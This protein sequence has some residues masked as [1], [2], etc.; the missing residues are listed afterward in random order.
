MNEAVSPPVHRFRAQVRE[1]SYLSWAIAASVGVH[2]LVYF[3]RYAPPLT[4]PAVEIDLTMSGHIGVA[5]PRHPA[6]KSATPPAP[7]KPEKDWVKSKANEAPPLPTAP[8]PA[9]EPEKPPEDA[10]DGNAG[11]VGLTRLPVLLNLGDLREI[12]RRFYPE[13]ARDAGREATVVLDLHVDESG[14]VTSV[15]VYR[16]AAPHFDAAA[17]RA[18]MLLRFSPA[19]MGE[20]RVP[21]KLRQAIKFTLEKE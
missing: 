13:D 21:V 3:A 1:K 10:D 15:D 20:K 14:R 18:G 9:P 12:L 6:P 11:L 5:G 7:R 8:S 2:G 16:S 17:K 19:F 4:R